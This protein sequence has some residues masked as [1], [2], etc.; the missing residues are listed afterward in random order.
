MKEYREEG[1]GSIDHTFAAWVA[2]R[3]VI[4]S[5]QIGYQV[6][7]EAEAQDIQDIITQFP[8]PILYAGLAGGRQAGKIFYSEDKLIARLRERYPQDVLRIISDNAQQ[9]LTNADGKLPLDLQG[10][11]DH[12]IHTKAY[13]FFYDIDLLIVSKDGKG[14]GRGWD[15][16]IGA[17]SG[18]WIEVFHLSP[19]GIVGEEGF[20]KDIFFNSQ[21]LPY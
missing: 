17:H 2:E 20:Y 3:P 18:T 15:T 21:K 1:S 5:L 19:K 10:L 14:G 9:L 13:E 12:A 6:R 4:E 11:S 8:E 7:N 16:I